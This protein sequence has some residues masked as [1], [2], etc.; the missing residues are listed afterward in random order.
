MF[1][2]KLLGVLLAVGLGTFLLGLLLAAFG[3]RVF[4]VQSYEADSFSRSHVGH[5]ALAEW[6]EQS[7]LV[8]VRARTASVRHAK[9]A[10]PLLLLEP[11]PQF[12]PMDSAAEEDDLRKSLEQ[13][14]ER[15][16]PVLIGL[17]KWSVEPNERRPDWIGKRKLLPSPS[18]ERVLERILDPHI[19]S[20]LVRAGECSAARA[21]ALGLGAVS[22][23]LGKNPQLMR[24]AE[25]LEGLVVCDQGLL[26]ART[27]GKQVLVADPALFNNGSLAQGDHARILWALLVE[28][29]KAEGVVI[30]ETLHGFES[31]NSLLTYAFGFPVLL[32]TLHVLLAAALAAWALSRRFG[33]PRKPPPELP[34]GKR[35]LVDNTAKLI[36]AAADPADSLRR[37]LHVSMLAVARRFDL[38]EGSSHHDLMARLQELNQT[39]GLR[40]DL[41]ALALAAENPRLRPT[42]A[43]RMA[44]RIHAWRQEATWNP[45]LKSQID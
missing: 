8:V 39:R 1:S 24:P 38:S 9:E 25:G 15:S 23:V 31:D 20:G 10:F 42:E 43:Q 6:L 7:G 27:S 28:D 16:A 33:S 5:H 21:D 3:N 35:L 12:D 40:L 2:P 30:D 13:A 14:K 41:Q 26:V 19:Q 36:L 17:P 34:P 37:Y 22:L 45:S 11:A 29:L 18:V 32:V 44:K 4:G